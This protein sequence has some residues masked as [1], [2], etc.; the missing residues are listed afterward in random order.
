MN[1]VPAPAPVPQSGPEAEWLIEAYNRPDPENEQRTIQYIFDPPLRLPQSRYRDT[2]AVEK[3]LDQ[4]GVSKAARAQSVPSRP[5]TPFTVAQ[6][7]SLRPDATATGGMG[8][9]VENFLEAESM[10]SETDDSE[11]T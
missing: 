6:E 1:P 11:L 5:A 2:E 9:S 8:P 10:S 3:W 7:G 4:N